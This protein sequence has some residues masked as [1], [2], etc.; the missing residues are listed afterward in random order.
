MARQAPYAVAAA[1]QQ[2]A[3]AWGN[4]MDLQY[5]EWRLYA[6]LQE[7]TQMGFGPADGQKGP[8]GPQSGMGK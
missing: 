2:T 4:G 3:R 1:A 8:Q 5:E 7:A 6:E